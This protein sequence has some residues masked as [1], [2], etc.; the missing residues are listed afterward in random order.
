V[1]AQPASVKVGQSFDLRLTM[2]VAAGWRVVAP[3]PGL[4]GLL[5]LAVSVP[6]EGLEVSPVRYPTAKKVRES[7]GGGEFGA[8]DGESLLL[9]RLRYRPEVK[10]GERWVRVRVRFQ[11]CGI[12]GCEAPDSVVLDA[13]MTVVP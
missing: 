10:P 3:E 1:V 11:P 2:T 13:P 4:K 5:G 6:G 9:V 8:L 7:L 12:K